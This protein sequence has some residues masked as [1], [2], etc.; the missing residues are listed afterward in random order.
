MAASRRWR[1]DLLRAMAFWSSRFLSV[2]AVGASCE[3]VAEKGMRHQSVCAAQAVY[4][5]KV[6]W[7]CWIA[8]HSK[9]AE[10]SKVNNSV[11]EDVCADKYLCVSRAGG[12]AMLRQKQRIIW[13]LSCCCSTAEVCGGNAADNCN[14]AWALLLVGYLCRFATG[15]SCVLY[16]ATRTE[17]FC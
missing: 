13:S 8:A 17:Y 2:A 3:T 9:E 16:G 11:M 14:S 12:C 6:A 7:K 4:Y 1:C 15:M 5:H 10:F